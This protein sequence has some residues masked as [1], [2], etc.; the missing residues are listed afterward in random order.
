MIH[1]R[2]KLFD[3]ALQNPA[4]LRIVLALA[5]RIRNES[6]NAPMSAFVDPTRIGIGDKRRFKNGI[7]EFYDGMMQHAISYGSFMDMAHLRI[8]N[9]KRFIGQMEI[10]FIAQRFVQLPNVVFELVLK[11]QDIFFVLFAD[12][13]FLPRGE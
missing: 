3:V 8:V 5:P 4:W 9:E 11:Q 12:V 6:L 2:E 7:K 13:K 1:A 10:R